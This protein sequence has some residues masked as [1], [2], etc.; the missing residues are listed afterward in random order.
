MRN[1]SVRN[2]KKEKGRN[3]DTIRI[4]HKEKRQQLEVEIADLKAKLK[5]RCEELS[6]VNEILEKGYIPP[7]FHF[8]I[9]DENGSPIEIELLSEKEKRGLGIYVCQKLLTAIGYTIAW[10]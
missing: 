4:S 5:R 6:C 7:H 10:E 1:G 3:H 2:R 9:K 8:L